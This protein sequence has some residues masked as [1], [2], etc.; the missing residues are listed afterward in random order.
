MQLRTF[1][2]TLGVVT[3]VSLTGAPTAEARSS[4]ADKKSKT[5]DSK[6]TKK[7]TYKVKPGDTLTKIADKYD[8]EYETTFVRIFNAN[9]DIDNPDVINVGD[10]IRIP[11]KG[12]KL[13]DRFGELT[14][15]AAASAPAPAQAQPAAAQPA[16]TP[17]PATASYQAAYTPRGSSAGNTYYKGYCTWYV[18]ERRSD[19][20]NMLG[21]GGQWSANAA[22]QG[23]PTGS[24]PRPGA[25]AEQ[26]GHVAYVESVNGNMVTVSEMNAA[27]G[28]GAVS[29]RTVPADTFFSYIY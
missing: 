10:K 4:S 9:K 8:K 7:V 19:L 13:P 25:V 6:E 20:P 2:L 14:K 29:T 1:L 5:S 23:I 28:F 26:A 18:K 12:E 22:A 24:T 11:A 16:T 3:A 15:A 21:N 27:A 17:A